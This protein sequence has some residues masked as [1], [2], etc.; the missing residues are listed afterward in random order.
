MIARSQHSEELMF[1]GTVTVNSQAYHCR[2]QVPGKTD[3]NET[4]KLLRV[5]LIN[6]RRSWRRGRALF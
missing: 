3:P 2:K 5:L 6:E 1:H 4:H